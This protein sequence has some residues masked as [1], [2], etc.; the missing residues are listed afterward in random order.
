M[1]IAV[2]NNQFQSV[3]RCFPSVFQCSDSEN[4]WVNQSK[5]KKDLNWFTSTFTFHL[6]LCESSVESDS[7][8]DPESG[9]QMKLRSD[10]SDSL[11]WEAQNERSALSVWVNMKRDGMILI[12][13]WTWS[14]LYFQSS[15][16][17]KESEESCWSCVSD[18]CNIWTSSSLIV[19]AHSHS[20]KVFINGFTV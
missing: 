8:R 14:C 9:V 1:N 17:L 20:L 11:C 2:F 19:S 7:L 5:R 16:G 13:I 4:R 6:R 15:A 3:V 12:V 10:E 18:Q